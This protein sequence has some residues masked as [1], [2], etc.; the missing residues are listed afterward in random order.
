MRL[1]DADLAIDEMP[2]EIKDYVYWLKVQ[3]TVFETTTVDCGNCG[4]AVDKPD[5]SDYRYC[6]YCGQRY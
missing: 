3:P 2:N 4:E 6:P 5:G 1:I